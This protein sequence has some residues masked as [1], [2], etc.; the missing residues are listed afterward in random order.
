V[1]YKATGLAGL[2]G[3]ALIISPPFTIENDDINFVVENISCV[4]EETFQ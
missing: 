4:L 3:D 2:D 1:T